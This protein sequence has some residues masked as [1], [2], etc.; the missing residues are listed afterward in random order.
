MFA[1]GSPFGPVTINGKTLYP[2]QG[3]NAYIFPG[4][5]LGVITSGMHH[6]G[7]EVFLRA[8]E[9]SA[10]GGGSVQT[11]HRE[12]GFLKGRNSCTS[13]YLV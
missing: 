7:E 10:R 3:N 13:G 6:I 11:A 2:G 8:A 5:A 1:S 4:V 9:V 12:G